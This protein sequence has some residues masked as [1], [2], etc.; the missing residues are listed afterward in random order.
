MES[1][2]FAELQIESW[3]QFQ[4]VDL[5][6]HPR[7]TIITGANGA[8]KTTL[9]N[10]FS[11]HFGWNRNLLATPVRKR[12]GALGYAAGVFA[13]IGSMLKKVDDQSTPVGRIKYSNGLESLITV[14][15]V[16]GVEY[17]LNLPTQQTVVGLNISSHRVLSRFQQVGSIPTNGIN[18]EQAYG[19]YLSELINRYGGGHS[20][21]SPIYRMKEAIIS[22]ALFGKG[23]EYAVG[24]PELLSAYTGFVEALRNM[25]P[26]SLGFLDLSIR[27]PDVVVVTRSGEFLI[28]A[29]SGGLSAIIELTWQIYIFSIGKGGFAVTIDEPENHLHPAMQRTLMRKLLKSFPNAQFIVATHS[30][31][32]VSSIKDSN[33]YVLA[34]EATAGAIATGDS[35]LAPERSV[36]AIALHSISKAGTANE[37]LRE[38]LGLETTM[39]EW[40]EDE[41]QDLVDNLRVQGLTA[42]SYKSVTEQLRQRGLERLIP[43]VIDEALK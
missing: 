10:I 37:I 14:P 32:I 16:T 34:Y 17:G 40:A 8:G 29:A 21:W 30:P 24:R 11:R 26:E 15:N 6:L 41:L 36:S 1:T 31:F 35:G 43:S 9:L 3:R 33:V 12:D 28:D 42:D 38:V 2:L 20:Q 4:K 27:T 22:M 23:N 25:L 5:I 18:P 19:N 39:P 7:L 13:K